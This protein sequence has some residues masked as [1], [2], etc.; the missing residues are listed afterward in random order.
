VKI[1]EFKNGNC[2]L[3]KSD[4]IKFFGVTDRNCEIIQGG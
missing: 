3:F 4:I 2:V 1:K